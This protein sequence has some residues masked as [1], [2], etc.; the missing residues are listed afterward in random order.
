M[1]NDIGIGSAINYRL[2]DGNFSLFNVTK[3]GN[4]SARALWIDKANRGRYTFV[5]EAYNDNEVIQGYL[6]NCT[7]TI[8]IFIQVGCIVLGSAI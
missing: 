2:K 3:D 5:I 6:K 4:V 7:Q 1:D 8:T